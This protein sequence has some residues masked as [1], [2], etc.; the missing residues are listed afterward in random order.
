M[1]RDYY[2]NEDAGTYVI[3]SYTDRPIYRPGQR[4][5]FKDIVRRSTE[6]SNQPAVKLEARYNVPTGA[7]L[8][9]QMR[10]PDG[11][12]ILNV[13]GVTSRDGC[14][15][16]QVDLDAE[17]PTGVYS[18]ITKIGGEVHTHDVVIASYR[19]PEFTAKVEVE[20]KRYV[21]GDTVTMTLHAEYYFGSPVVGAKVKYSVYRQQDYGDP[22]EDNSDTDDEQDSSPR[23]A[24]AS[25]YGEDVT[26]GNVQ[27]DDS[28]KAVIT[29]KADAPQNP[30]GPQHD[31][32]ILAATVT[33]GEDNEVSVDGKVRV[34]TGD[35]D[36]DATPE[37]SLASPGQTTHVLL[38][39]IDM[40]GKPVVGQQLEV[41]A[42]YD[43]W[44]QEY[45]EYSYVSVLTTKVQTGADGKAICPITPQREGRMEVKVRTRDA[46][47]NKIIARASIWVEGDEG[48]EIDTRYADLS[49]HTDK[50]KYIPGETARVL[51]SSM[52]TGETVLL[53]I[54]GE[55]VYATFT[56]A[57]KKKSQIIH[58]PILESYGP[59]V[60]LN[61]CYVRDKHFA[62][63]EAP[64]RVNMPAK[65]LNVAITADRSAT[66][67]TAKYQP[68][69]PITYTIKTTDNSGKPISANLSFGVVDEAIYALK[70]DSKTAL[71]DEFYPTRFNA[72]QTEYSF[73][74]AF[75]GDADK[76]EPEMVVRKKFPDTAY[77]NPDVQTDSAGVAKVTFHLPDNLTTWRATAMG[78]TLDTRV[79]RTTQDVLVTKDFL[80]RLEAPRFLTQKD[81]SRL[82]TDVLNDTGAQQSVTVRLETTNLQV[83]GVTSQSITLDSGRHGQM[84]WPVN[85][86]AATV[87]EAV[88]TVK[89]WSRAERGKPQFTDAVEHRFPV[90]AHGR[91]IV[92]G[93]AGD[94]AS[95][96][97]KTETIGSSATGVVPGSQRLI[98]RV[99]PS[100]A[101]ALVEAADYLIGYPYGCTEQ[102]MSR[103]LP[104]LLVARAM[105]MNGIAAIPNADKLP[106]MV[107]NSILRLQRLQHAKTGGWGWW[108][109][110]NDDPWMT[111]YVLCGLSE[112]KRDGYHVSDEMLQRGR[113]A[114]VAMLSAKDTRPD[115]KMFLLYGLA[116]A[117]NLDV[118]RKEIDQL[119]LIDLDTESV[120]L[121]VLVN[122][123][124]GRSSGLALAEI[125]RRSSF[126]DQMIHWTCGSG[127]WY[128]D[129]DD[130]G[131]T[132]MALRAIIAENPA[133]ERIA[134]VV[135]WLMHRRSGS[136]WGTTRDT[137]WALMALCEY[138]Q[139]PS[140][141]PAGGETGHMHV[142]VNGATAAD[143]TLNAS[144]V[145]E[146]ELVLHVPASLVHAGV[147]TVTLARTGA[148][149][150][151]FYS[152][153]LKQVTNSED[154]KAIA[155]VMPATAHL[156]A[157][158]AHTGVKGGD[159]ENQLV[160]SREYR[161]L[162]PRQSAASWRLDSEVTNDQLNEGD[163]IR[164]VLK[165]HAP[166][167]MQF[168]MLEDPFPAGLEVSE[169]GDAEDTIEW[170][171]WYSSVDVRD[172]KIAFFMRT[173]RAGDSVIEYN[174]RAKT[175]GSYH[176]MPALLQAMYSPD[177]HAESAE[178]R[179][180]IR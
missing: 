25:F 90:A 158:P 161:R 5:Y 64:L 109:H 168:V 105:K 13:K 95:G 156:G 42:G 21:R 113:Q 93:I 39:A 65:E 157:A 6:P 44:S 152:V 2:D 171:Y 103:F 140:G 29:F 38:S 178:D 17:A 55:R 98:V 141:H 119:K 10:N 72:V 136:Y 76:S 48:G 172:N 108:E 70:E 138:L 114:A 118:P 8:T 35:F 1:T 34:F 89:A 150:P 7:P 133:D 51:V 74:I 82:V 116:M 144:A 147:N 31:L 124:L 19:K 173:V 32:Y 104:D 12:Q 130:V 41:E 30:E 111:G 33:E 63:S 154:M 159:P 126:G 179:V 94:V 145:R 47:G 110:D 125:E 28:G 137:A 175:H 180:M 11:D 160:I 23:G 146:K 40:D 127:I 100:A 163:R 75:L 50:K 87:G 115:R 112:A 123:L 60:Y 66:S 107:R 101:G 4:V 52:R 177:M 167:Q 128:W 37:G 86:G 9:V 143:W 83:E 142:A 78:A 49:L 153:E 14:F 99:T 71:H 80:V 165:I 36:L 79:G 176:A 62:T 68:G 131:A 26:K 91:E 139:T 155:P 77:W 135:R 164:V 69:D 92:E 166:R 18:L 174:L 106:K 132:S 59:N 134:P 117:G 81:K 58:V 43:H 3:H 148:G 121:M 15:S 170:G 27:L 96:A 56:M 67:T 122:K 22:N 151:V 46:H 169:R 45:S 129:V 24:D 162:V 54:E 120:A 84:V 88:V 53:T 85:T 61:A 149:T 20:K 97:S 73:S 102:T 16:G 57:M